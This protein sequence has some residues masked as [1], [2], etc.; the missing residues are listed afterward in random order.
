MVD[1]AATATRRPGDGSNAWKLFLAV[2][3]SRRD[4]TPNAVR[5]ARRKE[6]RAAC[7]FVH[8]AILQT[9]A[10][11]G[12]QS[13]SRNRSRPTVRPGWSAICAQPGQ[14]AGRERRPV[15]RVVADGQGLPRPAEDHL[16]VG[17]HAADPQPV[18]ADPVDVG[19]AG[20]LEAGAGRVGH[21]RGAGLAPGGRDQL[22]RT[23]GGAGGRVGLVGVVQ[24]DDLDRLVERRGRRRRTASSGSRRSRSWG[25]SARRCPGRRPARRASRLEPLVVEA[26]GADHGVDPV[27]DAELQV[28]HH[29][30]GVGEVDDRLGTG[31]DQRVDAR[32]RRRSGATSS[33]S[34][35]ASTRGTLSLP[36][37]PRAPSTPTSS[38]R[39]SRAQPTVPRRLFPRSPGAQRT[40]G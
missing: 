1:T 7:R 17:D 9:Q 33:R 34:S 15:Q 28:A 19:A 30:V 23:P 18:H 13:R 4:T 29:H 20:A 22:R 10:E 14:H 21:R 2:T 27:A 37:L 36:T 3:E 11:L 8:C 5:P 31:L 32:R 25:R 40:G 38:V 26:G 39:P 35:A 24:L 16:L 6:G 12:N